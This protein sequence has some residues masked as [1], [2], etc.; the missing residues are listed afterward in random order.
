MKNLL[1][2][3]ALAAAYSQSPAFEV[4]TIKP[5]APPADGRMRF[6]ASGGPGSKDPERWSSTGMP[7][8]SLLMVAFDLKP[9][10]VKAPSWAATAQFDINAKVPA[11]ATKEQFQLMLQ[12]LLIE[13]FGLKF[14]REPA[15]LQ[16]YE[17]VVAKNGPKWKAS[18]PLPAGAPEPGPPSFPN[19]PPKLTMGNDGF[20]VLPPGLNGTIMMNGRARK[21]AIREP[22]EN[23]VAM[24]SANTRTPVVNATGLTGRFDYSLYWSTETSG[25]PLP[26]PSGA[27]AGTQPAEPGG[28]TLFA[29]LQDQLGLRLEAKKVSVDLLVVDHLEKTPTEN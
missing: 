23:L 12:N 29:A 22:I 15:E 28:P 21:Q 11:G 20:P 13:R 5:F 26:P 4:A 27:E 7:L 18:D 16:G 25:M 19:G 9:Y 10:Q 14:H 6:G 24:L 8:T 3:A 2:I 17:L 1:L